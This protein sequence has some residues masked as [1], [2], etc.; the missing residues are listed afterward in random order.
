MKHHKPTNPLNQIFGNNPSSPLNTKLDNAD[1]DAALAHAK[2]YQGEGNEGE[3]VKRAIRETMERDKATGNAEDDA[4]RFLTYWFFD[5]FIL[6]YHPAFKDSYKG[7]KQ[8]HYLLNKPCE[9]MTGLEQSKL[10]E[11]I[12]SIWENYHEE[13]GGNTEEQL[14]A[15]FEN[16]TCEEIKDMFIAHFELK[17]RF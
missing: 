1:F 5:M 16:R 10:K 15:L 4:W 3:F 17:G 13:N 6:E 12:C 7:L 14:K 9:E 8:F 11:D 2:L